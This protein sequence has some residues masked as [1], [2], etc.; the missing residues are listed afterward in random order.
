[1]EVIVWM[2]I[3]TKLRSKTLMANSSSLFQIYTCSLQKCLSLFHKTQTLSYNERR[4]HYILR[5]H[6]HDNVN[7]NSFE[8]ICKKPG[9]E[10]I[11]FI[12]L[13]EKRFHFIYF[14]PT[15][16]CTLRK[17]IMTIN[18][19]SEFQPLALQYQQGIRLQFKGPV[20]V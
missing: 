19:K 14:W 9:Q 15:H 3:I 5:S 7:W 8:D 18:N 10:S 4:K 20:I 1:M 12:L 2:L 6:I 11:L 16:L 17:A 13:Q